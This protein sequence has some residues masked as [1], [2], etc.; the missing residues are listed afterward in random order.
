MKQK[1][2]VFCLEIGEWFG[3]ANE[4]HSLVPSLQL[5]HS[6]VQIPYI[7]R[8]VSTREELFFYLR[9]WTQKRYRGFPILYLGFHGEPG[10]I[11]T[12]K[13]NGKI[14]PV[15]LDDVITE[16]EGKCKQRLIHFGSCE[17]TRLH[18]N[19]LNRYLHRT[20][21]VSMSGFDEEVDWFKSTVF[22]L[23]LLEKLSSCP[24]RKDS[25]TNLRKAIRRENPRL[26]R[27]LGFHMVVK[28]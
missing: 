6:A 2:G 13:Q 22:D 14:D 28:R 12:R 8:D 26:C 25:L 11:Y 24:L 21:A 10:T 16:L 19:T 5:L 23:I 17:V 1:K 4:Q 7:H 18:G 20:G 27:D 3:D 15:Q 9:K